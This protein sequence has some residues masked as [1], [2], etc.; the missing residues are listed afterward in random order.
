[1]FRRRLSTRPTIPCSS[2]TQHHPRASRWWQSLSRC[3]VLYSHSPRARSSG[4]HSC[5]A[6]AAERAPSWRRTSRRR[7][8]DLRPTIRYHSDSE[9]AH[10]QIQHAE[11]TVVHQMP[12]VARPGVDEHPLDDP[13]RDVLV[14]TE[15][16]EHGAVRLERRDLR[17][18]DVLLR[19]RGRAV[20][21]VERRGICGQAQ[22]SGPADKRRTSGDRGSQFSSE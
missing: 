9:N 1:M 15:G 2:P 5:T 14:A 16:L 21:C 18:D 6:G 13:S 7:L 12:H 4:R 11:L 8:A 3:R 19:R 10:R 22:H 20:P 17:L